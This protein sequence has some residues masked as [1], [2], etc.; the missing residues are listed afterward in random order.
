MN[1]HFFDHISSKHLKPKLDTP[2]TTGALRTKEPQSLKASKDLTSACM[3]VLFPKVKKHN[4]LVATQTSHHQHT[5]HTILNMTGPQLVS[6][7]SFLGWK[8]SEIWINFKH[9]QHTQIV[10]DQSNFENLPKIYI[11]IYFFFSF[12]MRVF[13]CNFIYQQQKIWWHD[14]FF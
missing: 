3:Q 6:L 2:E 14:Y 12:K 8:Q 5:T 1:K 11:Y 10:F 7:P 9:L 4:T 13:L